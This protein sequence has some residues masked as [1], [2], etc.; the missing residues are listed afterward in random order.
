MRLV[1]ILEAGEIERILCCGV[2]TR[3]PRFYELQEAVLSLREV[4]QKIPLVEKNPDDAAQ[5]EV[6]QAREA[7]HEEADRW[8]SV[9]EPLFPLGFRGDRPTS[10]DEPGRKAEQGKDHDVQPAQQYQEGRVRA[11]RTM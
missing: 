10:E 5:D 2:P 9:D 8:A 3:L 1:H 4:F 6:A 7:S 11:E